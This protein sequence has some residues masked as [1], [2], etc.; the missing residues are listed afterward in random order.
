MR[1]RGGSTP[2]SIGRS[3]PTALRPGS[4]PV[5]ESWPRCSEV[6]ETR[7]RADRLA[8]KLQPDDGYVDPIGS[9]IYHLLSGDLDAA[10][11]W[12]QK[13]IDQ[14]H[15]AVFF[16]VHVTAKALRSSPRWPALASMMNLR[17]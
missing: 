1:W 11:D 16:F 3:R 9:A 15:P 13:A 10:A 12:T 4:S 2:D 17:E 8:L 7:R 5:S 6:W 14:R